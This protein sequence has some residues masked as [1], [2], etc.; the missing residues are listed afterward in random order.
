MIAQAINRK[1]TIGNLLVLILSIFLYAWYLLPSI[2]YTYISTYVGGFAAILC[3]VIAIMEPQ[4]R[5][6]YKLLLGYVLLYSL[7]N[8]FVP[9]GMIFNIGFLPILENSFFM[10]PIIMAYDILKRNDRYSSLILIISLSLMF[11]IVYQA[12]TAVLIEYPGA[13][14]DLAQGTDAEKLMEWRFGNVGGFGFSYCAAPIGFALLE[15]TL[16]SKG[17]Y[18]FIF[19]FF[20]I[21]VSI[22]I[23]L[24]QYTTLLVFYSIGCMIFLFKEFKSWPIRALILFGC[25]I[26]VI[27]LG[28]FLSMISDAAAQGG[29]ESLAHH[30]EDFAGTTEGEEL[31]SKR[32][33]IALA[34]LN[35]W[36][37]SPIWGNWA[38]NT[39]T[40]SLYLTVMGAHSGVAAILASTG[41]I[42]LTLHFTI[43]FLAWKYIRQALVSQE[44]APLVFD[45]SFLFLIVVDFINPIFSIYEMPLM[46][47]LFVPVV[48][49]YFKKYFLYHAKQ[50]TIRN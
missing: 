6:L 33:D 32:G 20:L 19:G 30:F 29:F 3:L 10:L 49:F 24:V 14:R 17:I 23:F 41:L 46:T 50:K 16:R 34:A 48:I 18:K 40:N 5:H 39:P 37:D 35:I 1:F 45:I 43:L 22:V 9:G 27:F 31:R 38:V 12:T 7:L 15:L 42:G 2:K 11:Y 26:I 36:L 21:Y 28:E 44:C 25:L 8:F 47:F 4:T 13:A